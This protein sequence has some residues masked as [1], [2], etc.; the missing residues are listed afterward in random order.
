MI[1]WCWSKI[2]SFSTWHD[3][4]R[5]ELLFLINLAM[6][7]FIFNINIY[8]ISYLFSVPSFC[9][10][11]LH[12][13]F[14]ILIVSKSTS[15]IISYACSPYQFFKT[16]L[17]KIRF[18][19][20]SFKNTCLSELLLL[21]SVTIKKVRFLLWFEISTSYCSILKKGLNLFLS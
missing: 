2:W 11:K 3:R 7:Y 20:A 9:P 13:F 21:M 4:F 1:W 6:T 14:I 16:S 18:C 19:F 15:S 17:R 12:Y 5:R 10:S 8:C